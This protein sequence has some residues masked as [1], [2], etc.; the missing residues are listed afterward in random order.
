MPGGLHIQHPHSARG[1]RG[2]GA[3]SQASYS[4]LCQSCGKEKR[5]YDS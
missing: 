1:G 3:T 2:W 5:G 4:W